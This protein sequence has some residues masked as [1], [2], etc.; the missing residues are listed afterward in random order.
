MGYA[1]LQEAVDAAQ[2]GQTVTLDADA[3]GDGVFVA[4]NAGKDI[5]IDLGGHTYTV[6]GK[7]VG[8]T[9]TAT[10]GLHLEKGN[11]IT[12]KNGTLTSSSN[13]VRMLIQNYCDLT[14]E[15][16]TLDGTNLPGAA[17]Y[18]LSN[19]AGEV[20]IGAGTV[21]N[22]KD[23]GIAFDVCSTNYYP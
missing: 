1:S 14:L 9:G 17:P 11:A 23:G 8:S 19:N 4:A 18:T 7:A 10:Q 12:L 6:N 21:I 13:D 15:N 20:T 3:S 2:A 5:T 22:A 16:V